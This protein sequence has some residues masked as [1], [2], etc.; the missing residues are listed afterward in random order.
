MSIAHQSARPGTLSR[1]TRL[2]QEGHPL[3]QVLLGCEE[4]RPCERLRG[5]PR[6][7]Q[8]HLAAL[9]LE[10]DVAVEGEGHRAED[11]ALDGKRDDD[12]R[13]ALLSL[14]RER[15]KTLVALL[16]RREEERLAG[17]N[18]LRHRHL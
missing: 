17:P 14:V 16:N 3:A 4:A 6:Q 10:L 8:L 18:H 1:A 7:R 13:M 12:E 2:S 5:L 15:R 11:A 9:G